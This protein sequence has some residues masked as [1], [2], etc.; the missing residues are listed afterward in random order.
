MSYQVTGII[1]QIGKA[2]QKTDNFTVRSVIVKT[3]ND[4]RYPQY[5]KLDFT[6]S[7][8]SLLDQFN[9]GDKVKIDFN[10]QGKLDRN[11]NSKCYNQL[12]GWKIEKV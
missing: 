9:V 6:N 10:L 12:Q 1:Q 8:C 3:E 5:V 11:D 7:K 2:E 4:P